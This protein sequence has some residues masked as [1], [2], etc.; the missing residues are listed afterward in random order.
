MDAFI[1][2]ES[3]TTGPRPFERDYAGCAPV[4]APANGYDTLMA[5]LRREHV[6]YS[7]LWELTHRCNLKCVMCFNEALA[8][9][10]L[11][12]DECL[13]VLRQLAQAGAL[14]LTFTG[15][16]ILTRPDFF[17]IAQAARELGFALDLKTNGTLITPETA[18]RIGRLA[19]VQVDISLL[20]ATSETFDALAG[21]PHTLD[22]ALRGVGL[23]IEQGVR[24]KLNTLLMTANLSEQRAMVDVANKLGVY[25]ESVLKVSPTDSGQPK[26]ERHQLSRD[27]M[28][29]AVVADQT[30]FVPKPRSEE[31]RTCGVGLSSCLI[32]PYGIVYPCIELRVPAGDLRKQKFSEIWRSAPVFVELRERHV[33]GNLPDCQRCRCR[34]TARAGAQVLRRRITATCTAGIRWRVGRRRRASCSSIPGRPSRRRRCSNGSSRRTAKPRT[35]I[36]TNDRCNRRAIDGRS[37][38]VL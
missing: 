18:V 9:Q 6:P 19:P 7:V 17:T 36:F 34:R 35:V 29:E 11:S 23:L 1:P 15:G 21:M 8:E 26:A 32:S 2:L 10:E 5:R 22:R 20:G 14:R 28:V 33:F 3:V 27:Q 16:E 13:G 30:P 24:V 37:S 4:E 38:S 31:S 25:Y 12:T